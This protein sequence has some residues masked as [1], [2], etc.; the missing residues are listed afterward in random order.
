MENGVVG[1]DVHGSNTR[2]YYLIRF[3]S[4]SRYMENFVLI[5]KLSEYI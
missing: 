1:V 5:L 2:F 3:I 4:R